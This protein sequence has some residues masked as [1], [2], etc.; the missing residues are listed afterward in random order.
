MK[1]NKV[2]QEYLGFDRSDFAFALDHGFIEEA[3]EMIKICGSELPLKAFLKESGID[4]N[5]RP[6]YYQ[7][8]RI[9]GKQ[10]KGWAREHHGNAPHEPLSRQTSPLLNAAN[11][12]SLVGVEWFLSDTPSRLY[13]EYGA[14]NAKKPRLQALAKANGGFDQAVG[15]WL[16][17]RSQAFHGP[18][19]RKRLLTIF[20]A[21]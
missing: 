19:F 11:Q 10:M 17:Q 6:K 2:T 18:C 14:A 13:K 15:T 12:G 8:L 16:K 1:G 3:S 21:T 20:Q 7:G 4:E 5:E 9:G